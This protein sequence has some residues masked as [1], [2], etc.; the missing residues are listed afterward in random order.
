MSRIAVVGSGISGLSLAFRLTKGGYEVIL[1]EREGEPG[2]NIRTRSQ[3][4]YLFELGPQTIL[5]DERLLTFFRELGLKPLRADPSSKNRFI[6]KRGRLVPLPLNPVAFLTSPLLSLRAKLRVLKE[7]WISPSGA[8]DESIAD[9]VRRRLGAEFLDYIVAPFVSGVYGGDPERLSVRYAT[10]KIHALEREFGSLIRGALKR[11]ALGPGGVLISFEGGLA[12]LVKRL[13]GELDIRKNCAVLSVRSTEG[14]FLLETCEGEEKTETLVLSCPAYV[15][16]S[17]LADVSGGASRTLEEIDYVPLVVVN[18][19]VK[20]GRVPDGFGLL[21]PRREGRRILGV[22]FSSKLF[23][24][25][26]PAGRDLLT[27]YLGGA[28]DRGVIDE[29]EEEITE[30]VIRELKEILGTGDPEFVHV[31]KWR[32]AIPQYEIG[33]GRY[34]TLASE[35]ESNHRGL[36]LTGNYLSGVSVA[37]CLRYSEE[38]LRKIIQQQTTGKTPPR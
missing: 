13:S 34:L 7:P 3:S 33:Y 1:Y 28:T 35:L 29:S 30:T 15:A 19:G 2:G 31:Q 38:V 6:Y 24:G 25:R 23:P 36:Y 18:V 26:A 8:E 11:R 37:D 12:D 14:G 17:L 32:R 22:V 16:S 10:K 4:G 21:V 27:V 9:F 20:S 5:A